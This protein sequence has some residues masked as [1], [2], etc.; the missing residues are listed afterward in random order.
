MDK[1]SLRKFLEFAGSQ[2]RL[3]EI[4]RRLVESWLASLDMKPV[5][6]NTYFRHLKAAL[7][8]AVEWEYLKRNP[9]QGIKQLRDQEPP[10]RALSVE[11]V[12]QIL[13]AEE[14]PR[15]RSL[16]RFYLTTGC[17]RTEA[18]QIQVEDIDRDRGLIILRK[19]KNKRARMVVITEEVEAILQEVP[20]QVGRLWPWKP[21]TVSHQFQRTAR[22]AEIQ[23][24]LHDLRHTFGTRL[25]AQGLAPWTLKELMGHSDLKTTQRYVHLRPVD[26]SK[27]QN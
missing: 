2:V 4:N 25:A 7:S 12:Q 6:R 16:W 14:D 9:C 19:T 13:D 20:I 18:L 8:K 11:E 22:K 21:D 10:L 24:R 1:L 23:A 3:S 17:R 5:S 27:E 26:L 15:Y